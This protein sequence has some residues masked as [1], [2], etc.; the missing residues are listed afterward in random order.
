MG[1]DME[2]SIFPGECMYVPTGGRIPEGAD[3]MVMVEHSED[4]GDGSRYMLRPSAPGQNIVF[5]GED[6]KPGDTVIKKGKILRPQEIGALAAI[7]VQEVCVR[8]KPRVGIISTGDEIVPISEKPVGSQVR[9]INSYALCAFVESSGGLGTMLGIVGDDYDKLKATFEKALDEYDIVMISGGSSAG[10]RDLTYRLFDEEGKILFHGIAIKPGKPTIAAD[11]KGKPCFGLP[12]HPVSACMIFKEFV[13]P[14][15]QSMLGVSTYHA[16]YSARISENIPSNNGKEENLPVT[17]LKAK[18]G[19]LLASPVHGK[20]GL[21]TVL[22]HSD[23]Y[24]RISRDCEGI[25]S[26]EAVEVILF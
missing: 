14:L 7:G 26:G 18:D 19:S 15:I 16:R 22:S 6:T 9:D 25:A 3:S 20:S 11:V 4:Y 1:E 17:F 8:S 10:V 12:G 2:H 23:G 24:I 21:I 13:A 5:R